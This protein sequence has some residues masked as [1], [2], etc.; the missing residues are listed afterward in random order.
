[1]TLNPSDVRLAPLWIAEEKSWKVTMVRIHSRDSP[2]VVVKESRFEKVNNSSQMVPVAKDGNNFSKRTPNNHTKHC[3]TAHQYA[4]RS[5]MLASLVV[6]WSPQ[7]S[8]TDPGKACDYSCL[9]AVGTK[10]GSISIW[11]FHRPACY[12]IE[13]SNDPLNM[14]FMGVIQAHD[15]WVSA[16][17][18]GFLVSDSSPQVLVASGCCDGSVRIWRACVCDLEKLSETDRT[19]FSLF[20][21]VT[22]GDNVLVSVLSLCVPVQ[23]PWKI[24]L[25]VGKGSGSFEVWTYNTKAKKSNKVGS[26]DAHV[27]AVTGLAWAFD[28]HCL[29]SCSQDNSMHGWIY[30]KASLCRVSVPSNNLGTRSFSDHPSVS[31]SCYG[32][33]ISPGNLALA[34]ARRFDAGQLDHMYQKRTQRAAVEFF[35]I[36]G[37]Q[38]DFLSTLNLEFYVEGCSGFSKE[39]LEYWGSKLLWSLKRCECHTKHLVIWDIVVALCAFKSCEPRFIKH[40]V[41]RWLELLLKDFL[42]PSVKDLLSDMHRYMLNISSRQLHL[43]NILC[44]RVLASS[45]FEAVK[46]CAKPANLAQAYR[47]EEKQWMDILLN[48]EKELRERLVGLSLSIVLVHMSD[49]ALKAE[50][51]FWH[52]VGIA[53]MVKWV[54]QNQDLAKHQLSIL[55][56]EIE[57]L[58][59]RLQSLC[60]YGVGEEQCIF[61]S[62]TVPFESPEITI[63]KGVNCGDQESSQQH[64]LARCAVSMKVCPLTTLWFCMCC[65][66]RA[67]NLPPLQLFTMNNYPPDLLSFVKPL[68]SNFFPNPLCPFCGISLQRPQPDFLL[69]ISPV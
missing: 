34:V 50:F 40:I 6:A 4:S 10:S 32:V 16:L 48:S 68:I 27:Q 18:W 39:E 36:G 41:L 44:R 33:A 42:N 69:S 29:Y 20:I 57:G 11:K 22:A 21:E 1:M 65:R 58:G 55:A 26:Y 23:S 43:L 47:E 19:P 9:L 38:V 31:D 59:A 24:L 28:G 17:S 46:G 45:E 51:G 60:D 64:K 3:L 54:L 15:A 37:Q 63:C 56:S 61:C 53:Q 2:K 7:L 5:S 62:A 49:R 25:A 66:R 13:H 8:A 30:H 14:T 52:P 35:W 12:S 67:S